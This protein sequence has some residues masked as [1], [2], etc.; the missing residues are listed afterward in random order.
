MWY[1]KCLSNT[2]PLNATQ[3]INPFPNLI[4][5]V[6]H[7]KREEFQPIMKKG[8]NISQSWR[9][10]GISANREILIPF[11]VSLLNIWNIFY[12]S[13][14]LHMFRTCIVS[15]KQSLD[16]DCSQH[17]IMKLAIIYNWGRQFMFYKKSI[18]HK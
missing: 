7:E 6:N 3:I 16:Q 11:I 10:G 12:L 4:I 18:D 5:S 1:N 2:L 15:L 14:H 13:L 9:K 17:E 8:R